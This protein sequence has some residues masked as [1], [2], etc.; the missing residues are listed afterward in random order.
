MAKKI[1]DG[2]VSRKRDRGRPRL[3]FKNSIKHIGRKSRKKH[4]D[5]AEGMYEEVDDSGQG[6]RGM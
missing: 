2:K 3:T 5:P 6:E 1:S 4:E